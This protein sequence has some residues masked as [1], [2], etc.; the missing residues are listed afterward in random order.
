MELV[1]QQLQFIERRE[2]QNSEFV[3]YGVRDLAAG[4]VLSFEVTGLD[5]LTFETAAPSNSSMPAGA[6]A[7]PPSIIN[8]DIVRWIV[9]GLGGA[10]IVLA[11]LLYPRYRPELA[12]T[13]ETEPATRRQRLLLLLARLD[14]AY[15]AGEIDEAI[16][17]Q[18]R[19]EYKAELMR[20]MKKETG[21]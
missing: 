3:S 5:N 2:L 12:P 9:L 7:A 15:E 18:A 21:D 8:Q 13:V 1:S 16:Y 4:D 14:D 20:L 11:A 17:R 19:A 10:A 6:V